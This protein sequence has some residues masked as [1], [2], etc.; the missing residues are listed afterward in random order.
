MSEQTGTELADA[1]RRTQARIIELMRSAAS[2][3]LERIVPACPDWTVQ[4]LV[5]HVVSIPAALAAGDLPTG[6]LELWLQGLVEARRGA[7][8]ADLLDEWVALDATTVS[9]L[10]GPG[11]VLFGDLAVHEHDVRG[12]LGRPDH[13]ALEV[14]AMLP[15][16]VA[17]FASPL[18]EAGLG[19]IEVRDGD[20]VW[21]SHDAE[22]GWTLLVDPWEATRALNSRRTADELRRLPAVGEVEPYLRVVHEHLPLPA[23]SLAE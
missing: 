19:A 16:T 9:L 13:A 14:D 7:V 23:A 21:R 2:E 10:A 3:D 4:D 8:L 22:P 5:A 17:A 1:Y 6:D 18:R 11:E 20:Q 12:A 15:R